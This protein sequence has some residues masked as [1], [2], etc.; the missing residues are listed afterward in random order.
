[1]QKFNS[2]LESV[3]TRFQIGGINTGDYVNFVK[4]FNKTPEFKKL[5]SNIKE[6]L[7]SMAKAQKEGGYYLRVSALHSSAHNSNQ[8]DLVEVYLD[9][10][11]GRSYNLISIPSSIVEVDPDPYPNKRPL[12]KGTNYDARI[13]HKPEELKNDNTNTTRKTDGGKG[14]LRPTSLEMPKKNV[15]VKESS[16]VAMGDYVTLLKEVF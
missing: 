6:R 9:S 14:K 4:G 5:Q 2:L 16:N 1:M 8:A 11:D 3:Y 7:L 12:P 15:K 13:T 10:G